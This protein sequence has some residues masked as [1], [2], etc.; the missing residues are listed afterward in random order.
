M[1]MEMGHRGARVVVTKCCECGVRT[2]L[3]GRETTTDRN[4]ESVSNIHD[5]DFPS[6]TNRKGVV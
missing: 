1:D 5:R 2:S 3:H 6:L 4:H